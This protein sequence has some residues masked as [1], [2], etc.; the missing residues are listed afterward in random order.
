[1]NFNKLWHSDE[2]VKNKVG[3][4]PQYAYNGHEPLKRFTGSHPVVM[5]QR[6]A[7]VNWHFDTDPSL[8]KRSFKE[9]LSAWIEKHTGW[10]PGEYRNY[11][12]LK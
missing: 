10:R 8:A 1:L 2:W 7:S 9:K 11:Q 3:D 4:A 5:Q 6:I 12:L